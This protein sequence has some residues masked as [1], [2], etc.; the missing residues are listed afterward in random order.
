MIRLF[1]EFLTLILKLIYRPQ[2]PIPSSFINQRNLPYCYISV[3][4]SLISRKWKSHISW[5]FNFAKTVKI[6]ICKAW[7]IVFSLQ[8]LN[9]ITKCAILNPRHHCCHYLLKK[10]ENNWNC[11]KI[12]PNNS[13]Y[14]Q[15]CI[16]SSILLEKK[17]KNC[18]RTN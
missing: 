10:S 14:M 18:W 11:Y 5:N 15:H 9:K 12:T 8:R 3:R 7:L 6:L 1:Y 2:L 4:G 13:N 17:K 16:N